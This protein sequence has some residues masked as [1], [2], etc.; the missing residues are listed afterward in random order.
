ML[1]ALQ[2]I[3]CRQVGDERAGRWPAGGG[4]AEVGQVQWIVIDAVVGGCSGRYWV[5]VDSGRRRPDEFNG[6]ITDDLR[7]GGRDLA[8]EVWLGLHAVARGV[9]G[10]WASGGAGRAIG[11]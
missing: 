9:M 11:Q 8:A 5:E 1:E 7:D 4:A 10:S 2:G 3:T 6:V